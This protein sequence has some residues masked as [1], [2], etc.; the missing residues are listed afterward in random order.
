MKRLRPDF[1]N[2]A[3]S[4]SDSFYDIHDDWDLIEASLAKQYGIRIRNEKSMSWS[5]FSALVSGL[6]SDTPLGQMVVIR[7]ERDSKAIK[8]FS[9]EQRRIHTEW[10]RRSAAKQ[11]KNP[12]KLNEDMVD[13]E[14]MLARLFPNKEVKK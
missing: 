5:E 13:I 14:N 10:K 9:P 12:E 7:S 11:I 6:M 3:S 4:K 2:K 8:G 1:E